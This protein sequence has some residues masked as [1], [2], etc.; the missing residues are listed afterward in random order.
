MLV[1]VVRLVS[2]D[3][4]DIVGCFSS[5]KLAKAYVEKLIVEGL[6]MEFGMFRMAQ[7]PFNSDYELYS[8]ESESPTTI[9]IENYELDK[10]DI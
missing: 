4:N 6:E 5:L 2:C 9:L 1:Y 3:Q 7:D 8:E 10:G